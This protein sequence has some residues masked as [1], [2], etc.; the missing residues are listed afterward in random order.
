MFDL[1]ESLNNLRRVIADCQHSIYGYE[2]SM[3]DGLQFDFDVEELRVQV[4]RLRKWERWLAD[5][6]APDEAKQMWPSD[7]HQQHQET[8]Y[9]LLVE[10]GQYMAQLYGS[11]A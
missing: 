11:E 3:R 5:E 10:L 1:Q 8:G 7:K 2:Q 4:Y 9:R 6:L